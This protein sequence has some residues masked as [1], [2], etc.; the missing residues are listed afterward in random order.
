MST[1][2][3]GIEDS[4]DG[5]DGLGHQVSIVRLPH[6]TAPLLKPRSFPRCFSRHHDLSPKPKKKPSTHRDLQLR[7]EDQDRRRTVYRKSSALARFFPLIS[8]GARPVIADGDDAAFVDS[9]AK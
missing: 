4:K 8:S 2:S 3:S 5:W 7:K 9:L 1:K 6:T